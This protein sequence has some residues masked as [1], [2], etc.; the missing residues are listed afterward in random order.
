DQWAKLQS[1]PAARDR[2][3]QLI[4][5][6][7]A[8]QNCALDEISDPAL[9][10]AEVPDNC[11]A[12]QLQGHMV[13]AQTLKRFSEEREFLTTE[14]LLELHRLMLSGMHGTTGKFRQREIRSLGEGHR[15]I[16]VELVQPVV[17]NA[18]EWFQSDS[19][20]E[21]HEVEKS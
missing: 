17:E 13:A 8:R 7:W 15:P 16:P 3:E 1:E 12:R 9:W 2:F 19:F 21:M 20:A 14:D 10:Q 11:R 18:L 4:G 5:L 6:C